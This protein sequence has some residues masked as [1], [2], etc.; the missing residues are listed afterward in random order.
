M[1]INVT[2]KEISLVFFCF[3]APSWSW[4]LWS[5]I[6]SFPI[7][8]LFNIVWERMKKRESWRGRGVFF[9]YFWINLSHFMIHVRPVTCPYSVEWLGSF[10][11]A[12]KRK[13]KSVLRSVIRPCAS[14]SFFIVLGRLLS[15][16]TFGDHRKKCCDQAFVARAYFIP[17]NV[18]LYRTWMYSDR[19]LWR[20]S[21]FRKKKKKFS[22]QRMD[23]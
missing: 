15:E 9:L 13:K 3:F 5:S 21:A 14:R 20:S 12:A 16:R 11:I 7:L 22:K 6:W 2:L 4:Q 1:Q 23:S 18:K 19:H 8:S 17:S 10:C